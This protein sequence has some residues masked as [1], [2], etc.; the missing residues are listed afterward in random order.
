MEGHTAGQK[1]DLK[2]D[3]DNCAFSVVVQ[4]TEN[5]SSITL[6]HRFT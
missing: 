3:I 4:S 5:S 2:T 6:A 1:D